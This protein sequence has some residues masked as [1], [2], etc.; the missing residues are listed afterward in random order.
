MIKITTKM[1]WMKKF[2]ERKKH[3]Y[4]LMC[5]IAPYNAFKL[6]WV[7]QMVLHNMCI[8][9]HPNPANHLWKNKYTK[10]YWGQSASRCLNFRFLATNYYSKNEKIQNLL[11]LVTWHITYFVQSKKYILFPFQNAIKINENLNEKNNT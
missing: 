1:I 6:K 2:V 5:I 11:L 3:R 8:L 7:H 9:K 4:P 10:V